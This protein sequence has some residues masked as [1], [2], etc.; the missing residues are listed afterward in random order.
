MKCELFLGCE[1]ACF[2]KRSLSFSLHV[3]QVIRSDSCIP[4]H[5][6]TVPRKK[7]IPLSS[8]QGV[9]KLANNAYSTSKLYCRAAPSFSAKRFAIWQ[10]AKSSLEFSTCLCFLHRHC[11]CQGGSVHAVILCRV[12]A[13][14]P[15]AEDT[16]WMS[17][18]SMNDNCF[19][20][21]LSFVVCSYFHWLYTRILFFFPGCCN[22]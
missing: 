10:R 5:T 12:N 9:S 19:C 8:I 15:L 1:L 13:R 2:P 21:D 7:N 3:S 11:S 20:K 4:S 6:F 22:L 18:T 17:H 16:T 14:Q